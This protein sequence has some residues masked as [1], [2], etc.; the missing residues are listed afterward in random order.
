[1]QSVWTGI[2]GSLNEFAQGVQSAAIGIHDAMAGAFA[3]IGEGATALWNG[4]RDGMASVVGAIQS[5][6]TRVASVAG[7]VLGKARDIAT[8]VGGTVMD[9]GRGALKSAG[10]MAG[11]I[12]GGLKNAAAWVVG[13]ETPQPAGAPPPPSITV[14]VAAAPAITQQV[15]LIPKVR[16]ELIPHTFEAVLNLKPFLTEQLPNLFAEVLPRLDTSLIP[17]T[18]QAALLLTPVISGAVPDAFAAARIA[19]HT[20]VAMVQTPQEPVVHENPAAPFDTNNITASIAAPVVT[21]R[22]VLPEVSAMNIPV[23]PQLREVSPTLSPM[24]LNIV[25]RSVPEL[26]L[27][28]TLR[29]LSLPAL[30]ATIA[31]NVVVSSPEF[32]DV[33][34]SAQIFPAAPEMI[35]IPGMV[36]PFTTG[37][38]PGV[39]DLEGLVHL[40]PDLPALPRA[41]LAAQVQPDIPSLAPMQLPAMLSATTPP[42]RA[43]QEPNVPGAVPVDRLPQAFEPMQPI[44]AVPQVP[45]PELPVQCMDILAGQR[46]RQEEDR[47]AAQERDASLHMLLENV[48]AQLTAVAER[49]I[50]LTVTTQ[51]DGRV[52]AEAVYKDM[53]EQKIRNYET[54]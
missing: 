15:S 48:L 1:M 33:G 46:Q 8:G 52:V 49:P 54:L 12:W 16:E 27:G 4:L 50:D 13:K 18:F 53:R 7:N 23:S 30:D 42:Y 26:E 36:D 37:P 10:D 3:R 11:G 35:H 47:V 45:T 22:V 51:I 9:V 28:A 5:G 25:P 44:T 41:M 40:S 14:P 31:G 2:K 24:P 38:F 29:P 19:Q 32:P 20:P 34:L 39:P 21:P 6:L 43:V 17:R